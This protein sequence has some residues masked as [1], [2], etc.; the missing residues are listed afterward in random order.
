MLVLA[1]P[2][3]PKG[4]GDNGWYAQRDRKYVAAITPKIYAF[5]NIAQRLKSGLRSSL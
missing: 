2:L 3:P 4:G 1:L 5:N